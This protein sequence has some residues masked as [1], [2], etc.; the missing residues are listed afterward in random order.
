VT[1][2]QSPFDAIKQV[3]E[4]GTEF[5]SARDL[6]KV[7]GYTRW[8]SFEMPLKRAVSA[9]EGQKVPTHEHFTPHCVVTVRPQGGGNVRKD[10]H[11]SRYAMFLVCV[12]CAGESSVTLSAQAFAAGMLSGDNFPY[13]RNEGVAGHVYVYETKSG[14]V[15]IG[16]SAK[17]T[18]R[19]GQHRKGAQDNGDPVAR[20]YV[21]TACPKSD[22]AEKL[23]HREA[24]AAGAELVSGMEV[25]R[26][27]SFRRAVH[28]VKLAVAE[29]S[30]VEGA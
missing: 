18:H 6:M 5:W 30:R 11:L 22:A 7:M 2:P 19:V 29:T 27:I 15:K 17:P 3:R 14:L 25:F 16:R 1:S 12:M 24:I 26:G 23:A 20:S 4:D 21:S 8:K 10:Y 13:V 28:V 9:A